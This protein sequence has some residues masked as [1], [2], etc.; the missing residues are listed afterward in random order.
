M[1]QPITINCRYGL[2]A[3]NM[4][5]NYDL[6]I[7]A[8]APNSSNNTAKAVGSAIGNVPVLNF[9]AYMF[10]KS[11]WPSGS[12]N[13]LGTGENAIKTATALVPCHTIFND[14]S[15]T[16]ASTTV[17][18]LSTNPAS[19]KNGVQVISGVS[20]SGWR[21]LAK[22]VKDETTYSALL[23]YTGTAGANKAIVIPIS[24]NAC[25]NISTATQTIIGNAV[26]Y[27]LDNTALYTINTTRVF[28]WLV[29]LMVILQIMA[30]G[31]T[32]LRA[33]VE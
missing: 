16:G 26:A 19:E 15:L 7:L 32:L 18:L 24:D 21:S 29:L 17:T 27:L 33:R 25:A 12:G 13:N 31:H 2:S 28:M 23:E 8:E 22:V 5:S 10:G 1:L 11:N 20:A 4:A 30:T 6:V 14:L 9:K 3:A